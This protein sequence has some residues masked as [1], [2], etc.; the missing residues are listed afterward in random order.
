MDENGSTE[1]DASEETEDIRMRQLLRSRDGY[2]IR[3]DRRLVSALTTLTYVLPGF[4]IVTNSVC[5]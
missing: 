4:S 2:T 1:S 5:L 3:R